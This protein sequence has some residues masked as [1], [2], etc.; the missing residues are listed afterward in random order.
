MKILILNF[1][2]LLLIKQQ[3]NF[4]NACSCLNI[5]VNDIY[6][7]SN[8]AAHILILEREIIKEGLDLWYWK[9]RYTAKFLKVF[10]GEKEDCEY[11]KN[12]N[13]YLFTSLHS[14]ICGVSLK[15]DTE[16]LN[17]G[18]YSNGRI[19]INS[20][21]YNEEWNLVPKQVKDDLNNGAFDDYC[22]LKTST[23]PKI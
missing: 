16:Y 18:S 3:I 23:T 15:N 2:I 21:G 8:W 13:Y 1:L 20:C 12:N 17:F 4:V 11:A 14:S 10:K 22:K 6:C 7:R 19:N 9:V 5:T